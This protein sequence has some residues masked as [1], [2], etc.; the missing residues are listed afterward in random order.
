[1]MVDADLE[2]LTAAGEHAGA[3]RFAGSRAPARTPAATRRPRHERLFNSVGN[4]SQGHACTCS[5]WPTRR[6]S[7]D[8]RESPAID[9]AR[10]LQRRRRQGDVQRPDVARVDDH[11]LTLE[12]ITPDAAMAAGYDCAVITTNHAAF[13]YARIAEGS[14]LRG[15]H[16]ERVEGAHRRAHLQL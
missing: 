6:A 15:R 5:A 1:M 13:D 3:V 9:L 7:T 10:L 14:P 8:L 12:G 16:P 4:P 11:G 2:R